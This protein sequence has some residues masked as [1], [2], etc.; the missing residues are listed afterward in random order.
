MK[1]ERWRLN[2]AQDRAR[3]AIEGVRREECD[4]GR[5]FISNEGTEERRKTKHCW[6]VMC[7]GRGSVFKQLTSLSCHEKEYRKM[8]RVDQEVETYRRRATGLGTREDPNRNEHILVQG[9]LQLL[10]QAERWKNTWHYSCPLKCTKNNIC[11]QR[12]ICHTIF[13]RWD[14]ISSTLLFRKCCAN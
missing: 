7:S 4:K 13:A 9:E 3:R 6:K 11:L 2:R 1:G 12:I 14:R 5:Q 8:K 10:G